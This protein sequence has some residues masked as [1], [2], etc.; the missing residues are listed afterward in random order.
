[1]VGNC[2][3][4]DKGTKFIAYGNDQAEVAG[5]FQPSC[6]GGGNPCGCGQCNNPGCV[7]ADTFK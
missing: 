7:P 3:K 5:I 6:D 4:Y 1:M 2:D